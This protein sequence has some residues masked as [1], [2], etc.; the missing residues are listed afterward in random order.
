MKIKLEP[1]KTSLRLSKSEFQ[2]LLKLGT[3]SENTIFPNGNEI[4]F[5]VTLG[6]NQ[7]FS[8]EDN[9]LQL[10]LPNQ[11]IQSYKPNKVG[12]S[13]EFQCDN[14]SLHKLVFEVDIKK[15]PLGAPFSQ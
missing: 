13:F 11:L 14:S 15:A 2:G 4:G 3:L 10:V 12:L 1:Q 9:Q 5:M 8:F 7:H 6:N